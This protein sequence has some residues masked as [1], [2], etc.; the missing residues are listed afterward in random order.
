MQDLHQSVLKAASFGSRTL[1][2]IEAVG[3]QPFLKARRSKGQGSTSKQDIQKVLASAC[4]GQHT[5][6]FV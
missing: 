2:L 4:S 6:I 1:S 3:W 5:R